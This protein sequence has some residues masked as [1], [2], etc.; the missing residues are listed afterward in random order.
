MAGSADKRAPHAGTGV[1][2][3]PHEQKHHTIGI[4]LHRPRNTRDTGARDEHAR[5]SSAAGAEP[6]LTHAARRAADVA[7]LRRPQHMETLAQHEH[8]R[9]RDGVRSTH[10][11][12]DYPR[13]A[14]DRHPHHARGHAHWHVHHAHRDRHASRSRRG[15]ATRLADARVIHHDN[16]HDDNHDDTHDTRHDVTCDTPRVI[17]PHPP[18]AE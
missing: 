7:H 2:R 9:P 6:L 1:S 8:H 15:S 16:P 4:V 11:A 17:T 14:R 18:G 12:A 13:A 3:C 10:R 5:V